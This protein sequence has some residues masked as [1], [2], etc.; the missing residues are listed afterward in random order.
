MDDLGEN[1]PEDRPKERL[2]YCPR[3]VR[4]YDRT[5]WEA[6]FDDEDDPFSSWYD[7]AVITCPEGH[8]RHADLAIITTRE[9]HRRSAARA[10]A[11]ARAQGGSL[12][13]R[14]ASFLRT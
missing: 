2:F 5:E 11:L 4:S 10:A 7:C 8:N 9:D 14:V 6:E 12:W 13:S 3:C 1:L